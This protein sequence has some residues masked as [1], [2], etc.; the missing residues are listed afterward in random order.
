MKDKKPLN[1]QT[2]DA[3]SSAELSP[4]SAK[5]AELTNDLQR[6]RADFENYRKQ[7]DAQK[8]QA[9]E[10][11][12]YDTV[13]KVLPLLDDF[14]RAIAST[15]ELKPLEKSLEK[16][17]NELNLEKIDSAPGADFNPDLHDAVMMEDSDGDKQVIAE[18]LRTGYKYGSS[19]IR[20]AMVK[21]K[22]V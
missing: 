16:T 17:L 6:T 19:V 4:E 11:A 3:Q 8:A 2:S 21:V 20:P 7:M 13:K 14:D 5:I 12:K 1:K 10:Y 15:P 9:I 18:S 22:N